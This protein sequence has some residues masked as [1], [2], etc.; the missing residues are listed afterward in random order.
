MRTT[1]TDQTARMH[2]LISVFVRRTFQ[3]VHFLTL[4]SILLGRLII[5]KVFLFAFA[6]SVLFPCSLKIFANVPMFPE[7]KWACSLIPLNTWE[8]LMYRVYCL[9][10][11]NGHNMLFRKHS[12]RKNRKS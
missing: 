6:A 4:Q 2:R 1:K 10:L 11:N 12:H 3:Y 8:D 5:A 7:N 9:L